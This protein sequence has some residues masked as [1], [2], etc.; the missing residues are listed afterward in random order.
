MLTLE[1]LA[2]SLRCG[3]CLKKVAVVRLATSFTRPP[4]NRH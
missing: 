2:R 4:A 3:N 1:E